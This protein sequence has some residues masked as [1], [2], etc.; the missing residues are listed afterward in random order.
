MLGPTND[1][2]V[3]HNAGALGTCCLV[4]ILAQVASLIRS[5]AFGLREALGHEEM[6][7]ARAAEC[8]AML[9]RHC[10][11]YMAFKV[12]AA[13]FLSTHRILSAL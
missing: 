6:R 12:V 3:R 5:G 10:T 7:V 2:G 4:A 9:S 13:K 11:R 1:A 8:S